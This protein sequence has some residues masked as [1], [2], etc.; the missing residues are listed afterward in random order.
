MPAVFGIDSME[1]EEAQFHLETMAR[2]AWGI[3]LSRTGVA[4]VKEAT[5]LE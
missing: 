2:W 3:V 1:T 5:G 4:R